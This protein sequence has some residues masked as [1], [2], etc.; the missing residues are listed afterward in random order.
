MNIMLT[1]SLI[2]ALALG[3]LFCGAEGLIRGSSSLAARFRI[4]PLVVGITIVAFGTSSPEMVVAV[5]ATLADQG[6]IALGN[7]LGSNSFNI[8]VILGLTALICPIPVHLQI[9]KFDAPVAL[10]VVVI[11]CL[12]LLDG[13]ISFWGGSILLTGLV[14]YVA[15][16]L[17]LAGREKKKQVGDPFMA[18]SSPSRH[19]AVDLFL[20]LGG[21]GLLIFGSNLL[22]DNA[23]FISRNLGISE[24]VIGLTVIAA[25]TSLPE[26]ATSILAALRKQPDIAVGN[27]IGSNIF[28]ILGILGV[29]SLLSPIESQAIRP[30]DYMAVLIF[31]LLLLPFITTR[32]KLIRAEGGILL[33]L[34]GLYLLMLWPK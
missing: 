10:L 24:A 9:L 3:I 11:L 29:S 1:A 13:L 8:G 21:L 26:L 30:L 6:D 16:N 31:T 14:L 28:N 5:K 15:G 22:V 19:W 34:Y 2:V 33:A 23:I 18:P 17:W 4:S 20:V 27:V 32:Q 7:V 12:L 25:G